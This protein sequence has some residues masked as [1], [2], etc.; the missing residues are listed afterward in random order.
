MINPISIR[1]LSQQLCAPL[2]SK[3]EDV[4]SHFGAMQAQEY[5]LMR[6]AVEMRTRRPSER[7]FTKAYNEGKILRL[8]LLRGTWQ[9]ISA[10]DYPWMHRMFA[11]KARQV[12]GGWM[13][14][15]GISL[16]EEEIS[17]IRKII[18]EATRK[19]RSIT[20]EGLVKALADEGISMNDHRLSYHIR[21]AELDG[22]LCS[23][24]LLPMKATYS[25]ASEKIKPQAGISA[26]EALARL[27]RKYFQSHQP[28]TLEDF[29]WWSGLGLNDCRK[30]IRML[31]DS[32]HIER[33]KGREFYLLDGARTR[34]FRKGASLLIP[35]YDEYLIGYK[36]RDLVLDPRY[37][38]LAHNNSG[39]FQ[40]VIARDGIICGNWKPFADTPDFSYFAEGHDNDRTGEAWSNYKKYSNL[41]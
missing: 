6:W 5:R 26:D 11:A 2:F 22:V 1:L 39:I 41:I 23:G 8:H 27:T 14:S 12:I 33:I 7:A 38:H 18:T 36:S 25:L 31:G 13:S 3:P 16:P 34:G 21:F 37:R 9:L 17:Q 28:A 4:V 24:D 29:A 40:P 30:G 32:I 35:S 10:E 20:K 19:A 15:N